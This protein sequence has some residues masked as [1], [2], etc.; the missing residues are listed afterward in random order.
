MPD[1]SVFK[2]RHLSEDEETIAKAI[3][4]LEL[5]DPSNANRDFAVGFL[6]FMERVAFKIEQKSD[7]NYDDFLDQFKKSREQ[8]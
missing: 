5:H 4:Y 7:L 6:K 2:D 8:S 3:N 1:P